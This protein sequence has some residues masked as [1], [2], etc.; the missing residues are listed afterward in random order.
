[1]PIYKRGMLPSALSI[2]KAF[3]FYEKILSLP[4][5]V[6]NAVGYQVLDINVM[7][8]VTIILHLKGLL[9]IKKILISL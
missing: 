3:P 4:E 5:R 2:V 6:K 1:M 8:L 7:K 9:V